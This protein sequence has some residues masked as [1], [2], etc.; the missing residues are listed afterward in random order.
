MLENKNVVIIATLL[1]TGVAFAQSGSFPG[2]SPGYIVVSRS[3]YTGTPTTVT[4]GEALPP[5]C[6]TTAACGKGA[7]SDNGAYPSLTSKNNVWNNDNVDGSFGITS[8][9]FLDQISP[10]TGTVFNTLAIPPNM[11]TTS[12][13][14]K[15]ELALNLS[16][17]G[18]AITF[19]GYIAPPNTVDVSN[20]N[21]PAAYDPTNPSGGSYYRAVAQV[22]ANGAIQV[23]PTNSYSGNNGRAAILANGFYYMAGNANNGGVTPGNIVA[24]AGIQIAVPGQPASM[25]A[26]NIGTFSI[27]QVNNPATGAPYPADKLGKD[28]NFRGLTLFN[29]TLYTTK[30]SGSNG[31]NTVYQVGNA[32]STPTL[33]NALAAPITV[34]PGFPTTLAKTATMFPFGLFFANATTLYVADE[35]DGTAADAAGS[36]TA[37][38][39]K[40]SLV[41]GTWAL[42]YVLQNGLNLGVP[43][44]VPN[45]PSSLNP[46]TDGLRNIAGKV[47]GDGTVTIYGVT[48][49]VSTNGDQGADPNKLVMITDTL[50]SVTPASASGEQFTVVKSAAAG[51]VLRGVTFAPTAGVTP[52]PSVASVASAA[53]PSVI[54]IAPGSLATVIGMGL[55]YGAPATG[56][57]PLTPFLGGSSVMIIDAGGRTTLAPLLYVSPGQINFEVPATVATGIAQVKITTAGPFV[58]SAYFPV[59]T[60]APGLF[61]L[62][63]VGLA[64]ATAVKVAADGKT[65]TSVPVFTTNSDGT[66]SAAPISVSGGSVY[67]T[68]YGTGIQAAGTSGVTATIGGVNAKVTFAGAQGTSPG[69]DQ[70]NVLI[71]AS[72][73]GTGNANVQLMANG[74]SANPVQITVQ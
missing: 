71:P 4:V 46:S 57:L 63:G 37:G 14:S 11:I 51:E 64:A 16:A 59:S 72:L 12:F 56:T 74:I 69:L 28:N 36:T 42:D 45:Y 6:P 49:T 73:A 19:M 27:T 60:V 35:G 20:S 33:A 32:G 48:S 23:T 10:T 44:S 29:N 39:Q 9:I 18:T 30:G 3:V 65:Q 38:L 62:N 53:S 17:D 34:L 68:L 21:T 26:A 8:P 41:N 13:S 58:S 15:S 47:N 54:G 22:G 2:F 5:V 55:A 40:W 67:L 50:A 1:T 43:Y 7:A 31:I 52:Q 25:P 61:T 66:Y 24:T 70:V